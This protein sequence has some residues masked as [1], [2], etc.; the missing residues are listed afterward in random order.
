MPQ[1]KAIPSSGIWAGTGERV[2]FS[3]PELLMTEK[4][5]NGG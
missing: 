1:G 3:Y 2:G 4:P 5:I